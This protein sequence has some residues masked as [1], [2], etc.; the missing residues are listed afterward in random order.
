MYKRRCL[1]FFA[2][3]A[4]LLVLAA[5]GYFLRAAQTDPLCFFPRTR[6]L[7]TDVPIPMQVGNMRI[8]ALGIINAY[9]FDSV[10]LGTS[11]LENTSSKDCNR[12]IGGRFVNLS[13]CGSSYPARKI[14][15]EY[16]LARKKIKS[17]VYSLDYYYLACNN[18]EMENTLEWTGLYKNRISPLLMYRHKKYIKSVLTG[19]NRINKLS[20]PDMPA[21]WAD[22]PFFMNRF[23][24]IDAWIANMDKDDTRRFLLTR[25]PEAARNADKADRPLPEAD[26]RRLERSRR[27]AEDN[28]FSLARQYPQ[29]RFYLVFPPYWRFV[30]AD[31]L[32]SRPGDFVLHQAFVR[33]MALRARDFDN[34]AVFGFEDCAFVD[35]VANYRDEF[36]YHPAINLRITQD[37]AAGRGR[38]APETVDAYLRRCERLAR[39]FDMAGLAAGV[40][41]RLAAV[42]DESPL[43]DKKK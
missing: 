37:I 17:V 16:L 20:T 41:T 2:C 28:L 13:L 11:L 36:H 26:A 12:L 7:S 3:V 10:I 4:T 19:R 30:Y 32:L 27:Y 1:L 43:A 25:L 14:V 42:R 22:N 24:G 33:H 39:R 6:L 15:L 34:V 40:E 23:G 31:W 9:D 35:D 8:Q 29:T 38:L 18:M 21:G 5:G